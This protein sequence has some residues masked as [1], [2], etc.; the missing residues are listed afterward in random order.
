[1]GQDRRRPRAAEARVVTTGTVGHATRI[2]RA[3]TRRLR[4]AL[5]VGCRE[6]DRIVT[7]PYWSPAR[8]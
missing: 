6:A 2:E 7:V 3:V 1:M 4:R 5:G 8:T